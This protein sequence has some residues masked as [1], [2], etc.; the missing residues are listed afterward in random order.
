[1]D[2]SSSVLQSTVQRCCALTV[3]G[4]HIF[5]ARWSVFVP[6]GQPHKNCLFVSLQSCRCYFLGHDT[7][8]DASQLLMAIIAFLTALVPYCKMVF[9]GWKKT[10]NVNY[11]FLMVDEFWCWHFI[12]TFWFLTKYSIWELKMTNSILILSR[13]FFSPMECHRSLHILQQKWSFS[14]LMFVWWKYV[15]ILWFVLTDD[16]SPAITAPLFFLLKVNQS[17]CLIVAC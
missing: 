6:K 14:N 5:A 3:F 2:F 7:E 16:V 11:S 17:H 4:E 8:H 12:F 10:K 15:V 9:Q 1:M 13:L